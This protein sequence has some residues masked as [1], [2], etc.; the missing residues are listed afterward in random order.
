MFTASCLSQSID[1]LENFREVTRMNYGVVFT[2]VRLVTVV[3]DVWSH[4][5]DLS[6]PNVTAVEPEHH[7]LHCNNLTS[8]AQQIA[9]KETCESNREVITEL[10]NQHADM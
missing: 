8:S 2:P 1:D 5:F 3:T 6:L 10:Y 4:V 9:K 7:L